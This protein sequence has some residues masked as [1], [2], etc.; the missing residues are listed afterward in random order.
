MDVHRG[1]GK[2]HVSYKQTRQ[3]K[4]NS[5]EQYSRVKDRPNQTRPDQI[6]PSRRAKK[7]V[8]PAVV[9]LPCI[10]FSIVTSDIVS[11]QGFS[12]ILR[13]Q[14]YSAV[15]SKSK[16]KQVVVISSSSSSSSTCKHGI[17]NLPRWTG[18]M[19]A[20]VHPT[21]KA[22]RTRQGADILVWILYFA[23]HMG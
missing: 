4:Q 19:P 2:H 12:H 8:A 9:L 3:N 14:K 1:Q 7:E 21:C 16:E 13:V 15:Q 22:H 23:S 10:T 17:R 5:T 11:S 20:A 18:K 6:R